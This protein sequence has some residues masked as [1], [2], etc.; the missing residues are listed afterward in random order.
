MARLNAVR[1]ISAI[2][3]QKAKK[4]EGSYSVLGFSN[5]FISLLLLYHTTNISILLLPYYYCTQGQEF[6]RLTEKSSD[7]ID[8][9]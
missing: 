9:L 3:E 5:Q 6:L 4:R 7:I 8:D 1:F 2:Y